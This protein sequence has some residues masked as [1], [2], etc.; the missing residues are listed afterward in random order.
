MKTSL[1][2][3]NK[4]WFYCE[5]H[6]PSFLPLVGRLPEFS[7]TWSEEPTPTELQIVAV[8]G[9]RV[10]DLKNQGLTGVCVAAHWLAR[11]VMPLK[12]QVH[13]RWEYNGVHDPTRE[14]FVTPRPNKILELLQ[15]MFQNT[16][17]LPPA[18]QVRSYHLEVNRD[19][20]R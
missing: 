8:L 7:D 15:E 14:T 10:N 17:S 16:N 3:W 20:V 4:S 5:N 9:N 6:E 19:P 18:E 12:K 2:G 11:Q 13:P 1:K